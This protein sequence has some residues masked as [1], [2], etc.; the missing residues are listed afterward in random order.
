MIDKTAELTVREVNKRNYTTFFENMRVRP[1]GDRAAPLE[2][3][4]RKLECLGLLSDKGA[5]CRVYLYRDTEDGS[6]YACKQ[7][8]LTSRSED[9]YSITLSEVQLQKELTDKGLNIV[10]L[11]YATSAE[12]MEKHDFSNGALTVSMLM[13][14]GVDAAELFSKRFKGREISELDQLCLAHDIFASLLDLA[15]NRVLHKDPKPDNVIALR[16][17]AKKRN[18]RFMLTDLNI[19][20]QLAA[21]DVIATRVVGSELYAPPEF[22]SPDKVVK[23]SSETALKW[24]VYCTG[25]TVMA[26]IRS[27]GTLP[28]EMRDLD[29]RAAG[30]QKPDLSTITSPTMREL[31]TRCL[32]F[33]PEDR[34]TAQEVIDMLE[35]RILEI[36]GQR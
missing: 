31:F 26:L 15:E 32:K 9:L 16:T 21:G 36:T 8:E 35:K 33:R 19:S 25:L 17:D 29:A 4:G 18:I 10:P 13:P 1:G 34:P 24:D 28:P 23:L 2:V 14:Y 27:N 30:T 3:S 6:E 11:C 22:F 7:V 12:E 5:T 20:K